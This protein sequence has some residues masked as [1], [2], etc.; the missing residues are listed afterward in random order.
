M[1][2]IYL[3]AIIFFTSSCGINSYIMLR[4]SDSVEYLTP[5][6]PKENLEYRIAPDDMIRWRFLTDDGFPLIDPK[7]SGA[8]ITG[9]GGEVMVEYN[10]MARFPYLGRVKV[11]GLTYREAEKMLE[12]KYSE[13]FRRPYIILNVDNRRVIV[14]TGGGG[15]AE[16]IKLTNNNTTIMEVLAAAGGIDE[17]GNA[18]NVKLIR[19][20]GDRREVYRLDLSTIEN[21]ELGDI[22][23]QAEDIV[24]VEPK[25]RVGSEIA[26]DL[27]PYLSILSSAFLIANFYTILNRRE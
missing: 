4:D 25:K 12:D 26:K 8:G 3:F 9:G 6:S 24:Y 14:S 22:V 13:Y 1:R 17:R 23:V 10:G 2:F 16:V 5:P 7:T 15:T 27:A 19:K 20:A 18:K 11:D 21:V